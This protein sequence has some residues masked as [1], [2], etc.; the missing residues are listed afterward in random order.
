MLALEQLRLLFGLLL[1]PEL[2]LL[3]LGVDSR[4]GEQDVT[5]DEKNGFARGCY[6][7]VFY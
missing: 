6:F 5:V 7:E 4:G 3:E 2:V 1:G